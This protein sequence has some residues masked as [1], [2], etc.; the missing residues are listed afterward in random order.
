MSHSFNLDKF[1]G[2]VAVVTGASAGIGK[3][4]AESL[5][6]QGLVV[7]ALARRLDRLQQI[8]TNLKGEKGKLVPYECDVSQK[9]QI[10]STFKKITSELGPIHILVNN[11]GLS[12]VTSMI[13]GDIDKW[14][15]TIDTNLL[16]VAICTKEAIASMKSKNLKGHI[17]NINSV[18]GHTIIDYPALNVYCATK[19]G[20]KAMTETMRL[21]INSEKLPIKI[22]SISPGY[23]K[24]EFTE[25]FMGKEQTLPELSDRPGLESEDITNAVLYVLS[26][27]EHV[28]VRELIVSVQGAL[29]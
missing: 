5:V 11:A 20:L 16:A 9:D 18:A 27:P 14:K 17:I 21:E 4:I 7:A 22:T 10:L 12:R 24:T 2:K 8:S 19:H 25:A 23:V 26:T 3:S 1:L 28:N 29:I 15:L 6:K 13:S